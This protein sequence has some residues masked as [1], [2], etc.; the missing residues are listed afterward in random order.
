[1][2]FVSRIIQWP[3]AIG[4]YPTCEAKWDKTTSSLLQNVSK[5][6]FG[7]YSRNFKMAGIKINEK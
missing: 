5:A 4:N 6:C 3:K 7:V 2:K 1:M